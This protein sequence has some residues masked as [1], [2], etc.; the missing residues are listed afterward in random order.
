MGYILYFHKISDR[1]SL[2]DPEVW[3][4]GGG[5]LDTLENIERN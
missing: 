5:G 1:L 3:D 4:I 2:K